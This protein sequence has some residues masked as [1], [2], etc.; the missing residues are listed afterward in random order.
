MNRTIPRPTPCGAWRSPISARLLAEQTVGLGQLRVD[1]DDLYWLEVRPSDAGRSVLV[2]RAADGSRADITAAPHNV[3][4]RVHEYGGGAYAVRGGTVWYSN[5]ADGRLHRR[6]RHDAVAQPITPEAKLRYADLCVDAP[7]DRLV[8]VREDHEHLARSTTPG[9]GDRPPEPQNTIVAV[10]ARG[11]EQRVLVQGAD[12]Y[13]APRLDPAGERICWLSWN[14][15]DM[16][17]DGCELWVARIDADGMPSGAQRVAG[18]REESICQPEWSPDGV[19]HFVSDRGGW[20]NLYRVVDGEVEAL[21]A[22]HAEF[23]APMWQLGYSQ[24]A[25]V[26]ASRIACLFTRNGIMRLATL[27]IS[28]RTLAEV[29]APYT[30][31]SLSLGVSRGRAVMVA[32]SPQ[33]AHAVVEVDLDSGATTVL[34][35]AVQV[36]LDEA[37]ISVPQPVEFPT[38]DGQTAYALYY[39]PTNPEHSLPDGERPPLLVRTHGGPTAQAVAALDLE[40][41]FWTSRG[42]GFL[43]VDYGGS[44]GYGREYRRRLDGRWGVVDVDDCVAGAL[45]LA[46]QGLADPERL[47]ID[48]GSAGGYTTLCVLTFRDAFAAGASYF[49][50]ADLAGLAEDTHKFESRYLDRLVGPYPAMRRLYDERS[51]IHHADRLARPVILFQGL[52]DRVVPP[53]QA[54]AMFAAMRERGVPCAY[55]AFEGEDHG[56]RRADSIVRSHEGELYFYSRV[57]GFE[58]AEPLAPVE[59]A[60]LPVP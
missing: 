50:V 40:V 35:A 37:Y 32:A 22:E 59:I 42:I 16:P 10:P 27:D 13:A 31:A 14:H 5:M 25:F 18:G 44:S 58:T 28:S 21:T 48:G 29:P 54:E 23:G 2:R 6:D 41:Q 36:D 47:L 17:W 39:A 26:D 38:A 60:N 49:G 7:R 1:G 55:V 43:D 33:Q 4:T 56:F 45:H 53:N 15:P 12:F 57:L 19:L 8:C 34:R 20:W 11:G 46:R 9:H 51:P 24:Y 30:H 3:R 52:D